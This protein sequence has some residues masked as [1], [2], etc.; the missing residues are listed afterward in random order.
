M[1]E[2]AQPKAKAAPGEIKMQFWMFLQ[3]QKMNNEL[4]LTTEHIRQAVHEMGCNKT[5]PYQAMKVFSKEGRIRVK[6]EP[7]KG[8]LITF[9][10]PKKTLDPAGSTIQPV[11]G[12]FSGKTTFAEA[13][14]AM[15]VEIKAMEE[16]LAEKRSLRDQLV[17]MIGKEK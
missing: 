5:Y 2:A 17:A 14:T 6:R 8:M 4:L 16:K 3:R 11:R 13:V 10:T 9:L 15:D 7:G 12:K 1:E